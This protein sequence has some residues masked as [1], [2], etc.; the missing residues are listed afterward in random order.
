MATHIGTANN[1][2]QLLKNVIT[3]LTNPVNFSGGNQWKLVA[4][5]TINDIADEVILKGVGDGQDDIY[6]G[7]KLS[8]QDAGQ[9]DIVINGYAGYDPGLTWREQPGGIPHATLPTIPLV[10]DSFMTYWISANAQRIILVVEL[11]TQYESAYIGLMN[12]IAIERQYPY[13]LVI[14]GS[15]YE[16]GKWTDTTWGHSCFVNPGGSTAATSLRVRRPDGVWRVGLNWNGN[17]LAPLAPLCVWPTN[18]A[19]VRTVTVYDPVLTLENVVMYPFLLYE[20]D[21]VGIIGQFDGV[22]W[23][24]NREDI[25]TKDTITYGGKTYKIFNNVQRRDNDQYFAIEWS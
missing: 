17:A 2:P 9:V 19:P 22:Y 4:P 12:P 7:F 20:N 23:V 11:S 13:P 10:D 6:I 21:P 1:V 15:Y 25:A 16:G 3:F 14:G 18:V 8:Y 5:L 24:G